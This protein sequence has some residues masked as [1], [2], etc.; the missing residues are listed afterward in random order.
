[1]RTV[2]VLM[3]CLVVAALVAWFR[4]ASATRVLTVRPATRP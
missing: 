1:M 4:A 2:F 3:L